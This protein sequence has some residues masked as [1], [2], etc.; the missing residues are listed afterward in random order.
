M[1]YEFF[2]TFVDMANT[3]YNAALVER[4]VTLREGLGKQPLA[5][6]M[7]IDPSLKKHERKLH[8]ILGKKVWNGDVPFIE[9]M[10]QV[11]EKL[12]NARN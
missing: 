5:S 6:L 8:R 3:N 1:A 2:R 12:I 10:E 11:K 4:V 7:A 9:R